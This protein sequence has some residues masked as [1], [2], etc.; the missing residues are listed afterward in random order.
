ML[1]PWIKQITLKTNNSQPKKE[2]NKKMAND[3]VR[4][5]PF[6]TKVNGKKNGAFVA[7]TAKSK[8]YQYYGDPTV[9]SN[10]V[11]DVCIGVHRWDGLQG[12]IGGFCDGDETLEQTAAR[13]VKEE[14][15]LDISE[16]QLVPLATHELYRVVVHAFHV[17]LGYVDVK[18]LQKMVTQMSHAE[19]LIAEGTPIMIHL[20]TYD[21]WGKGLKKT[22]AS[23]TLASAVKEE[24]EIL[25]AKLGIPVEF[26][27]K[28]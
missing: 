23:N 12:L 11:V 14:I 25:I 26:V 15:N 5:L 17:D 4:E 19:H 21:K 28:E 24:L 10:Q 9:D 13:E 22:L 18:D 16:T 1:R 3:L 2:R 27:E 7:I 8:L 6:G 20:K